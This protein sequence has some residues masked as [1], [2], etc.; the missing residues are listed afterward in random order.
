[1]LR[2]PHDSVTPDAVTLPTRNG[3]ERPAVVLGVAAALFGGL[4][5]LRLV[6]DGTE[7]GVGLLLAIPTALFA[8]ELGLVAGIVCAVCA[9]TVLVLWSTA[10]GAALGLLGLATRTMVFLVVGGLAGR[11]SD[12]MREASRRQQRLMESGL[13]LARL[14][15]GDE[16]AQTVAR[17]ARDIVNAQGAR[18]ELLD[19]RATDGVAPGDD[20]VR[21]PITIRGEL[22]GELAVRAARRLSRD[23]DVALGALAA[24]AGIAADNQRLLEAARE[25]AVL[26]V[27]LVDA[28]RRL[29]AR[30]EQLR[31][32]LGGQEGERHA[33]ALRLH[34]DAAQ[35]VAAILLGIGALERDPSAGAL[36]PQLEQLRA[37][38]DETLGDLR[39]LAV[40]IRPPV[41]DLGL[42]A[43][44]RSLG[45]E[46]RA[47][48]LADLELSVD[49]AEAGF[50]GAAEAAVYRVVEEAL[51]AYERPHRA[52]VAV[53]DGELIV[54]VEG[55]PGEEAR[56]DR[57]AT[58]GARVDLLGGSL[59]VDGQLR[60]RIPLVV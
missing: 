37:H 3:P 57:V 17:R 1:M 19:G 13:A 12:R 16:L 36:L 50:A 35:A 43:A 58:I 55:D 4:A 2:L 53:Q 41:L 25:K 48:G 10:G 21:V 14:G 45:N 52:T 9:A 46:H 20:A 51:D 54:T 56:H 42:E 27:E 22:L 29:G 39:D 8:L 26:E 28:H 47:R 18:V 34:E 59:H 5:A 7:N 6:T 60:A 40:G 11:F 24:Q 32:V 33:L 30:T 15:N 38:V 23:D 31:E 49:G 44:L